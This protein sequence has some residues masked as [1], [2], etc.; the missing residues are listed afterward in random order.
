MIIKL[1]FVI[2]SLKE[3]PTISL[4]HHQCLTHMPRG[5]FS[6]HRL[7]IHNNPANEWAD[8]SEEEEEVVI[9]TWLERNRRWGVGSGG[10]AV[11]V[12]VQPQK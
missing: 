8:C 4:C 1:H 11:A 12:Q 3:S 6:V 7:L 5:F 2:L 9:S 10:V